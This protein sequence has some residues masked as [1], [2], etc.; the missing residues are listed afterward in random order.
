MFSLFL[1][2]FKPQR[3]TIKKKKKGEGF[4]KS[5]QVQ[6]T[7]VTPCVSQV[8]ELRLPVT[9]QYVYRL[10]YE[11]NTMI[12]LFH[13]SV[14]C[15]PPGGASGCEIILQSKPQ[16]SLAHSGQWYHNLHHLKHFMEIV[17][18]SKQTGTC[19]TRMS[20]SDGALVYAHSISTQLFQTNHKIPFSTQ[21]SQK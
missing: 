17:S 13:S 18:L 20:H 21:Q 1:F 14:L 4:H 6:F 7:N 2:L 19:H 16:V 8:C 9:L 12:L 11:G 5:C 10:S 3:M 15:L